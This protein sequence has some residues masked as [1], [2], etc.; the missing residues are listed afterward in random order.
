MD[1]TGEHIAG[2]AGTAGLA[3]YEIVFKRSAFDSTGKKGLSVDCPTGKVALG[4]GGEVFPSLLDANRDTAP[5]AISSSTMLS[6]GSG[7]F[8]EARETAPYESEWVIVV[9]ATCAKVAA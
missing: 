5:L 1:S 3:E 8:L 2:A 9:R 6:D 7:W 4:G